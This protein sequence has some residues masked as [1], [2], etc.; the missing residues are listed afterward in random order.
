ML[1][2]HKSRSRGRKGRHLGTS[3]TENISLLRKCLFEQLEDRRMLA[4]LPTIEIDDV[5]QL[6]GDSGTTAFVFTVTRSGKTNGTSVDDRLSGHQRTRS[7]HIRRTI[8][9]AISGT[10][11]FRP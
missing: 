11:S 4:A 6:E 10:L 7:C 8:M 9:P 1:M 3:G 5:Q 2:Q